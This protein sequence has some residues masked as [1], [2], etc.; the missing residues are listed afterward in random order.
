ME[1]MATPDAIA[2]LTVKVTELERSAEIR[3]G[4]LSKALENNRLHE[5][6]VD[7]FIQTLANYVK[8]GDVDIEIADDL[9]ECFGRELT[10][11]IVG[12]IRI[13]G[14][15]ELEVPAYF[16]LDD[17]GDELDIHIGQA[18]TSVVRIDYSDVSVVEIEEN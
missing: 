17:I 15:I 8:E 7:N 18:Y 12:H 4:I 6:Y 9:A 3:E 5:A 11:K 10:R 2:Q 13:E 14:D 16:D 1:T